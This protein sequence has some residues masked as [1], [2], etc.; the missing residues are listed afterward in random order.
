MLATIQQICIKAR[1]GPLPSPEDYGKYDAACP[2]S[3]NRIMV[4]AEK[5][6]QHRHH[7]EKAVVAIQSVDIP[8]GRVE[9]KRGQILAFGVCIVSILAGAGIVAF[10]PAAIAQIGG[11][12]FGVSALTG[13]VI[14]FMTGKRANGEAAPSHTTTATAPKPLAQ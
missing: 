7:C 11:I 13:I 6:Q 10:S 4:M 5:E 3:A 1:S 9:R 8:A 12:V 14:A 2:G